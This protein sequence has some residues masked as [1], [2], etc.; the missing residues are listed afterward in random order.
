MKSN[1]VFT[2]NAQRLFLFEDSFLAKFHL[3]TL[4]CFKKKKKSL[5]YVYIYIAECFFDHILYK[6][7]AFWQGVS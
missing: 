7:T 5:V 6:N 2:T 4:S 3:S 1:P